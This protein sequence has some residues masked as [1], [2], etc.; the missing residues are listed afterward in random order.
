MHLLYQGIFLQDFTYHFKEYVFG[1][2]GLRNYS[3]LLILKNIFFNIFYFFYGICAGRQIQKGSYFGVFAV[4]DN[5][6]FQALLM[7]H[8]ANLL[9]QRNIRAGDINKS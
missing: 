4:T 8:I 9:Q 6:N 2:S 3:E 5:N 7:Q 1:L